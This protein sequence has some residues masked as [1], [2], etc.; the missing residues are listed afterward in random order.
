MEQREEGGEGVG[1][2]NRE[3]G[4]K[5]EME[6][7]GGGR[8]R[9]ERMGERMVLYFTERLSA[10]IMLNLIQYSCVCGV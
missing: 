5:V 8:R 9:A 10:K 1:G 7:K 4:R 2:R 3:R 6:R